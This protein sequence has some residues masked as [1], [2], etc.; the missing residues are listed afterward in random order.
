[1]QWPAVCVGKARCSKGCGRQNVVRHVV[2]V[3]EASC[4]KISYLVRTV[5]KT[6]LRPER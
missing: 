4:S 6:D 5:S 1:M 2:Y 3:D